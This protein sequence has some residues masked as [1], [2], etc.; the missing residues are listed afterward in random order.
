MGSNVHVPENMQ[1][2]GRK[3]QS[4]ATSHWMTMLARLGYAVKGVVYLMIGIL[5]VQLA[6]GKGG[7]ATDQRGA[8]HVIYDQP[9]GRFLLV[10]VA[11]G[12]IGFALWCFIQALFDTE[13]KGNKAK[14][15]LARVGYAI[16]GI[17]YGL[18]GIG[19]IQLLAGTGNGGRSSTASAQ[20]W[21]GMVLKYGIGVALIV[22]IG[23]IVIGVAAYMFYRAYSAKFQQKLSLQRVNEQVRKGLILLGRFGYA[24]LGVVFCII[25]IFLI[26]AALQHNPGDAKGLDSALQVV[27]QEPFGTFLLAIVALGLIAYGAYSFVEARYRRIAGHKFGMKSES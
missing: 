1:D 16:V 4:A 15:I 8:I 2:A 17:S 19:T 26:V 25:G 20:N 5:A 13:G 23:L 10:V 7:E 14:G 11:I 27:L 9:F 3:A 18:L 21:T 24:A 12:L 22:L 6:V